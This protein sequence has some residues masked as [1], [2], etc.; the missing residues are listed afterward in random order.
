[1]IQYK[2]VPKEAWQVALSSA[3]RDPKE[4]LHYLGLSDG[5]SLRRCYKPEG[6]KMLVPRSYVDRMKKG[7]WNDPLLRQVLPLSEEADAVVG[8]HTDPVGDLH[9][10]AS[11][12]VLHKYHGRALLVST[13]AC[14]VHCRYCFRQHFSYVDSMSDKKHWQETLDY[15]QADSSIHEVILSGGDPLVLTDERLQIMCEALAKI[16]HVK[17]IRFHTRVPVLLPERMTDNFLSWLSCLNV[18]KVMVVHANH[19]NEVDSRVGKALVKIKQADV[20]LL[21]QSVLLKGVND[22][23]DSLQKLS[24]VLFRFSVLPY[25]LHQLDRVKGA[26]HFDVKNTDALSLMTQLKTVLPGYLVPKYVR[27]VSGERSKQT[28]V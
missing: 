12:G 7:D 26:A 2:K 6:F 5:N 4:L 23:V 24:E 3:I 8:F 28:I 19:A 10:M 21:N 1:M 15:L 18:Q 9:A 25:Y 13:G 22:D 20:T 27:E 16:D 17:T 11:P 14:A